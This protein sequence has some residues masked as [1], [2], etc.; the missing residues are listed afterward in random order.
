MH[1]F[2]FSLF[3]DYYAIQQS[4][5]FYRKYDALFSVLDLSGFP[6]INTEVGRTGYSRHAILRALIV[7]HTVKPLSLSIHETHRT[8]KYVAH[9][10]HRCAMQGLK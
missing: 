10:V 2:Q 4:S 7:K 6:S 3:Y 8:P 5:N 9:T 1:N